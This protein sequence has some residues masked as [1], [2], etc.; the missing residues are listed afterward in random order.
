M[1]SIGLRRS[2][3]TVSPGQLFPPRQ[4]EKSIAMDHIPQLAQ[5]SPALPKTI[6]TLQLKPRCHVMEPALT[7][8][9][10]RQWCNKLGDP[11]SPKLF[12][13][14]QE[15][16]SPELSPK[17]QLLSESMMKCEPKPETK[18]EADRNNNI[19]EWAENIK[20]PESVCA[21]PHPPTVKNPESMPAPSMA[22]EIERLALVLNQLKAE[23]TPFTPRK[24]VMAGVS[25]MSPER[26]NDMGV[27]V[28][29]EYKHK[30]RSDSAG[31][32]LT[33][34]WTSLS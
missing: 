23:N 33:G 25:M 12:P 11:D 7:E 19:L 15:T 9:E 30:K 2:S 13:Y 21:I 18:A 14:Y 31:S 16:F 28:K 24:K 1:Y 17:P 3:F 8:S 10:I 34:T 22:Q 32:G 20:S 27:E 26:N 6:K 29:V 4:K 5:F